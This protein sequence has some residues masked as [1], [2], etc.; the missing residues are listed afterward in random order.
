VRKGSKNELVF[1]RKGRE[2][3]GLGFGVWGLGFGVWGLEFRGTASRLK[4]LFAS[5]SWRTALFAVSK[6]INTWHSSIPQSFLPNF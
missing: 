1:D 4:S 3:W 6:N 2:V 5:A